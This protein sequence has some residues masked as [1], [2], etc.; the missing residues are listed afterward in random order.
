MSS[1]GIVGGGVAGLATALQL[2]RLGHTPAV[3]EAGAFTARDGHA[4]LLL[5]E[6]LKA[7]EQLGLS[8][9]IRG[10]GRRVAVAR[11]QDSRG[12]LAVEEN[13]E[14]HLCVRRADLLRI[15]MAA[16]PSEVLHEGHE[17]RGHDTRDDGTLDLVFADRP[18]RQHDFLV[19]ADGV[20][21]N[22]RRGLFPEAQVRPPRILE[23]VNLVE[24]RALAMRLGPSFVKTMVPGEGRAV[25][26]LGCGG[27]H[28]VWFLQFD[29]RRWGVP[30]REPE[31]LE[32][33]ARRLTAG[34]VEP[35]PSLIDNT[36]FRRSHLW[37]TTDL[38]LLPSFSKGRVLLMGDAAHPMLSLTSQGANQALVDAVTLGQVL[39]WRSADQVVEAL[40]DF[41]DRRRGRVQICLE[42]GRE[43]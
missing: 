22:I 20:R 27:N 19:G 39:Q 9:R 15:L 41:N 36:D 30:D 23:L 31:T 29:A 12:E 25:G 1:P 8:G 38:D 14:D 3:Y 43:L 26:A 34:W 7:L 6:G 10:M 42:G 17:Y 33:L 35:A 40:Q 11:V 4:F 28:V 5:P 13:L 32:R 21:S 2:T 18:S 24:D 37:R 16:V